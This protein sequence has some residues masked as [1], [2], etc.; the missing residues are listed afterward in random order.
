MNRRKQ[1]YPG[2]VKRIL[3][4]ALCAATLWAVS[5]TADSQTLIG[6]VSALR[7]EGPV[8]ALRW[9]LGDFF[10]LKDLSPATVLAIAESP[11][12]IA[13]R[14]QILRR[15]ESDSEQE[16]QPAQTEPV[17]EEPLQPETPSGEDNGVP[18]RTL[19]PTSPSGYTVVGGVYISN[20]TDHT[21]DTAALNGGGFD[22][23]L[24]EEEPQ[25]LILHTLGSESY[26][27]PPGQSYESSG[28]YRTT[29][30]NYNVVRVGDEMAKVFA[31][32]GISALHDRTLYD[33]PEYSGAYGRSL[34]AINNYLE[35][36]PSIQFVIDVHRDAIEDSEGNQY[37]VV[38]VIDGVGTAA[39]M[40]IVV[41]SDGSGLAHDNWMENLKL[42]VA[43]Q[44]NIVTAYP[45]LMRPVVLRNSR[46]NQHV[47]TGSLLVEVGAA[48]N[49]LDE[50]LLAARLFTEQL[51]EVVEAKNK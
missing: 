37:K 38:S 36:Y 27:M 24:T 40:S 49:S 7:T 14:E 34:T 30:T 51:I 23:T 50:A 3:A 35:K 21:L 43:V 17:K 25:V 5:V 11:L 9:E 41:G 47:T 13:A 10:S 46:Y 18:A 28:N 1:N 8:Q 32:A 22:A 12:L 16:Q 42:A 44:Q 2:P 15:E 4:L 39:Q 26:T 48:G 33:Y 31:E 45:T 20:G 19:V 6:A 29:D